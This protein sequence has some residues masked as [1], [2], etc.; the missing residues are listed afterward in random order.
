MQVNHKIYRGS[1]Q[2]END[3]DYYDYY[4]DDKYYSKFYQKATTTN[5][6]SKKDKHKKRESSSRE[7]EFDRYSYTTKISQKSMWGSKTFVTKNSIESSRLKPKKNSKKL[8]DTTYYKSKDKKEIKHTKKL[9]RILKCLIQ[10]NKSRRELYG[11]YFDIWY[12]KTFYYYDDVFSKSSNKQFNNKKYDSKNQY[13]YNYK[14]YDDNK[15]YNKKSKNKLNPNIIP[16]KEKKEKSSKSNYYITYSNLNNYY[17]DNNSYKSQKKSKKKNSDKDYY[18]DYYNTSSSNNKIKYYKE[19]NYSSKRKKKE[20]PSINDDRYYSDSYY[21]EYDKEKMSSNKK[22]NKKFSKKLLYILNKYMIE[23]KEKSQ[24]FNKWIDFITSIYLYNGEGAYNDLGGKSQHKSY[25]DRNSITN[26]DNYD[27]SARKNNDKFNQKDTYRYYEDYEDTQDKKDSLEDNTENHTYYYYNQSNPNKNYST[28]ENN[29]LSNDKKEIYAQENYDSYYGDE[30]TDKYYNIKNKTIEDPNKVVTYATYNKEPKITTN[31]YY[32]YE[33]KIIE[34]PIETEEKI[35]NINSNQLSNLKDFNDIDDQIVKEMEPNIIKNENGYKVLEF[36]KSFPEQTVVS[37]KKETKIE[38]LGRN[39]NNNRSMKNLNNNEYIIKGNEYFVLEEFDSPLR[40]NN[41]LEIAN[42]KKNNQINNLKMNNYNHNTYNISNNINLDNNDYIVKES[43]N[44]IESKKSKKSKNKNSHN[45]KRKKLLTKL[46]KKNTFKYINLLNKF[47]KWIDVTYNSKQNT[48]KTDSKI[49]MINTNANEDKNSNKNN[50]KIKTNEVSRI[51]NSK[52]TQNEFGAINAY[53]DDNHLK[54]N[55]KYAI[56]RNKNNNLLNNKIQND[57]WKTDIKEPSFSDND[58]KN[59]KSI[60]KF[61][62]NKEILIRNIF[63]NNRKE[64]LEDSDKKLPNQN[65]IK[66][67]YQDSFEDK[68]LNQKIPGR[69]KENEFGK[70]KTN[71]YKNYTLDEIYSFK[72]PEKLS[73]NLANDIPHYINPETFRT[74]DNSKD[75]AE[76]EIN[77][78]L[79]RNE[80]YEERRN[81]DEINLDNLTKKER[82]IYKKLRKGMHL[83]RKAIKTYKKR[84]KKGL[85]KI[86]DE[87]LKLKN[88]IK[89]RNYTFPYGIDEF[90]SSRDNLF[91]DDIIKRGEEDHNNSFMVAKELLRIKKLKRV[92]KVIDKKNKKINEKKYFDIKLNYLKKWYDATFSIN[93]TFPQ[94]SLPPKEIKKKNKPIIVMNNN[95]KVFQKKNVSRRKNNKPKIDLENALTGNNMSKGG[96][97]ST[98]ENIESENTYNQMSDYSM[99]DLNKKIKFSINDDREKNQIIV[100]NNFNIKDINGRKEIIINKTIVPKNQNV[101]NENKNSNI[102]YN[103]ILN[104]NQDNTNKNEQPMAN[105]MSN[106]N[107]VKNNAQEN[108]NNNKEVINPNIKEINQSK[109]I[110]NINQGISLD[111]NINTNSPIKSENKIEIKIST[112]KLNKNKKE[113]LEKLFKKMDLLLIKYKYFDPWHQKSKN[114]KVNEKNEAYNEQEE[115][116][117]NSIL[118]KNGRRERKKVNSNEINEAN[119]KNYKEEKESSEN[120]IN[121]IYIKNNPIIKQKIKYNEE[122][123]KDESKFNDNS[124]NNSEIIKKSLSLRSNNNKKKK[125][126]YASNNLKKTI[127]ANELKN[128]DSKNLMIPINPKTKIE[129]KPIIIEDIIE[130]ISN[131]VKYVNREMRSNSRKIIIKQDPLDDSEEESLINKSYSK[132]EINQFN[133]SETKKEA[134]AKN[135]KNKIRLTELKKSDNNQLNS[136]NKTQKVNTNNINSI[137]NLNNIITQNEIKQ[138]DNEKEKVKE[139]EKK[140]EI[141]EEEEEEEEEEKEKEKEKEKEEKKEEVKEE[142]NEEEKEKNIENKNSDIKRIKAPRIPNSEISNDEESSAQLEDVSEVNT[143]YSMRKNP[144]QASGTIKK[145]NVDSDNVIEEVDDFSK[146]IIKGSVYNLTKDKIL[147]PYIYKLSLYNNNAI[148]KT[149]NVLKN[150]N[151]KLFKMIDSEEY[152]RALERNQKNIAA[153][154]IYFLFSFFNNGKDF[155]RLKYAFNK[156]KKFINIFNQINRIKHIKNSRG[157]CLG[158]DCEDLHQ[159]HISYCCCENDKENNKCNNYSLCFNCSC[160]LCQ[161]ILKK[162]LIRHK[163]MKSVNPKRYYLNLWYKHIFNKGRTINM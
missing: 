146:N 54:M 9:K 136:P 90:R 100:F 82:R 58:L 108:P 71:H 150:C 142:K 55:K 75:T 37:H 65:V 72:T 92:V 116:H 122:Y 126:N 104:N 23:R 36:T 18:N 128:I 2:T 38:V 52:Y 68:N 119:K 24:C 25:N 6:K 73:N 105:I 48:Q 145:I 101:N 40:E 93:N 5:D 88:F 139:K 111:K 44:S 123:E 56:T 125:K 53:E 114:I 19:I 96:I 83:L 97:N 95:S 64:L 31:K 99:P 26:Y 13:N 20:K 57:Y 86:D 155:Y 51:N 161:I 80:V 140:E 158:C 156:W 59:Q 159:C 103:N 151:G 3:K 91:L 102:N 14:D 120:S 77:N 1:K 41:S 154:Q 62:N 85:I 66:H 94:I 134:M 81:D 106:S 135:I 121:H 148:N 143:I 130:N 79:N 8:S 67:I 60:H 76:Q 157:H 127:I 89:W 39:D 47:E 87:E 115:N 63:S 17:Q 98:F 113:I 74:I 15:K 129:K 163:F 16:N 144:N 152:A 33:K 32:K 131:N 147:L 42:N 34:D 153:Y 124:N 78:I 69:N 21:E 43:N 49:I 28:N 84:K 46:L 29:L 27:Y 4:D 117:K 132:N 138:N 133:F 35:I 160:K 109:K 162:I 61:G 50:N 10:F 7:D 30:N 112:K 22:K 118:I 45:E 141:E 12:D 110:E 149:L 70:N 107:Q 11:K 137:N